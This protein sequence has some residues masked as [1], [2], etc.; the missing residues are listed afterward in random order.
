MNTKACIAIS[1]SLFLT[2]SHHAGAEEQ[3]LLKSFDANDDKILSDAEIPA[4]LS[5]RL[6]RID[7]DG[8]GRLDSTELAAIPERMVQRLLAGDSAAAKKPNGKPGEVYAPAAREEFDEENLQVGDS[9]PDF[10][11]PRSDG[12]GDVTLADFKGK[13]PV[14][15]VFGSITCS[16]FR[17]KVM[18]VPPIYEKFKEDAEFFMVYIREAHPESI[19]EVAGENGD[20]KLKKFI[21]TNDFDTR[22]ENAKTCSLLIETPFPT[23]VDG[24]DNRVKEAYAGWP[25]R[26]LVVGIDG[27]ISYDGGLGPKGFVPE[28]LDAW[29]SENIKR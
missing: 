27:K 5:S 9:A 13:K 12:D 14:V 24:E 20:K 11:L 17:Q 3:A 18:G 1:F 25:I 10:T 6:Q 23:L 28:K 16:P 19:V 7:R 29:L 22:L 2:P 8:D 21:Q 26:L 15:L 4:L